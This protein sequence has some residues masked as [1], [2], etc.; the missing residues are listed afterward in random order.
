MG[1]R[2]VVDF[3][4]ERC[5]ARVV[6]VQARMV[7]HAF[8]GTADRFERV[9]VALL[10]VGL[11]RLAVERPRLT[12]VDPLV[13]LAG[14]GADG[15]HGPVSGRL[16]PRVR[17]DEH[18]RPCGRVDR[19]AVELEGRTPIE[20]DVQLLLARPGLVVLTD[21][22]AVLAGRE[23]V[24]SECVDPEVLAHR[25]VSAASLDVVETRDLPLRLVAHRTTS[26]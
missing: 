18:E 9:G 1:E 3:A 12:P 7:R 19:L 2:V 20:D 21:Q 16:P 13:R 15:K 22:R 23:G 5:E 24:D 4:R 11:H 8:E 14:C 6:V 26:W 25:D 17:P 10:A